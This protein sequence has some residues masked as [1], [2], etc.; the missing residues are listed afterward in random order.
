MKQPKLSWIFFLEQLK[1]T[2]WF[3]VILA[4]IFTTLIIVN[5]TFTSVEMHDVLTNNNASN[6]YMLIIGLL[7]SYGFLDYFFKNG[8][9]RKRFFQAALFSSVLLS[10]VLGIAMTMMFIGFE[11]FLPMSENAA[12]WPNL[13][14]DGGFLSIL[15]SLADYSIFHYFYLLIG[16][17]IGLGFYRFRWKIGLLFIFV[18]IL[19]VAIMEVLKG[20]I[21]SIPSVE[22]FSSSLQ[23]FATASY[24]IFFGMIAILIWCNY[25]LTKNVTIRL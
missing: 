18:G 19:L 10:I 25:R 5:I 15:Q 14:T 2:A 11:F 6:V 1:W 21:W 24:L 7:Y 23:F 17:F 4:I 3:F 13:I 20:E 9:T 12:P 16:W 8:V 22:L